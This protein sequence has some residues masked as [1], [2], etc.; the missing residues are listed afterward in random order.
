[1]TELIYV[2]LWIK[3]VHA[4]EGEYGWDPSLGL[5]GWFAVLLMFILAE[6]FKQ[7][8]IMREDLEGTI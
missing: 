4:F 7:G 3:W 1:M 5:L 2:W 6:I 8:A